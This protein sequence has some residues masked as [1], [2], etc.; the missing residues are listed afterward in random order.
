MVRFASTFKVLGFAVSHAD[1]NEC[2]KML[3]ECHAL[4]AK[5]GKR[6]KSFSGELVEV[7]PEDSPEIIEYKSNS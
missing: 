3:E 1:E 6:L 7:I 2:K 5:I 4:Q